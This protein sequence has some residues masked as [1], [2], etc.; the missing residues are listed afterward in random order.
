M[1]NKQDL[2]EIQEYADECTRAYFN[3]IE[4]MKNKY[5]DDYESK[6]NTGEKKTE[7]V[8]FDEFRRAI[9]ATAMAVDEL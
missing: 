1:Y 4:K 2:K 5:G 9:N 3:F 7:N 6:M 8:L